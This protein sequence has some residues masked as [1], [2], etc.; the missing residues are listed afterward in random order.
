MP[1]VIATCPGMVSNGFATSLEQ[2][3]G[4]VTGMDEL[5]PGVTAK[6]LTPLKTI[7]PSVSRRDAT[8]Y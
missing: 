7:A 1:M 2:P 8:C 4:N 5:P 6:R 3:R